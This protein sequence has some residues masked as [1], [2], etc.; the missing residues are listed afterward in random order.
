MARMTSARRV[1][2]PRAQAVRGRARERVVVV[3]P[4]L[5]ERGQREPDH[6]RRVV[7]DREA[8]APEEV[9]DGVDRPRHVVQEERAHEPAPDEAAQRALEREAVGDE[10]DQRRD[11]DAREGE[12]RERLVEAAHP[13]VLVELVAY[14]FQSAWPWVSNSQPVWACQ[15]PREP[16]AVA[17]VRAVRIALLVSV[18]VVL[19]VVGDPVEHRALQ[20]HRAEHREQVLD[21]LVRLER[22]VRE[23]AVVA[24]RHAEA[25]QHVRGGH[26][27]EVD[28]VDPAVPEQHDGGDQAEERHD[29]ADQVRGALRPGHAIGFVA[30]RLVIVVALRC[31]LGRSPSHCTAG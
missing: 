13:A 17:H 1:E 9:A 14:F 20:A 15:R 23:Q 16:G 8:P 24:D 7:G 2:L 28:P 21:A 30:P 12:P 5:A 31:A 3:V 6:V 26:D 29:D 10:A 27:R 18:G 22:A 11:P 19:A 4:G 25:E